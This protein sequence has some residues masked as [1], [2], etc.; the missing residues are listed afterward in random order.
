MQRITVDLVLLVVALAISAVSSAQDYPS[1]P[2]RIIVPYASG[3]GMADR[4]ARLVAEKLQ[5]KWGQPVIV[6]NRAGAAANIGSEYVAKSS[7][8]GY[9][10]L[11]L[12]TGPLAV[13]KS[14]FSKLAYDPDAFVPVSLMVTSPNV[15]IV[16]PKVPANSLQQLIA[17]MTTNPD[18]LNYGS[19]GSGGAP[20]LTAEMFKAMAKVKMVHVPYKGVP[21]AL[22]DLLG[23][24]LDMMFVGLGSVLQQ[25][26]AGKLR[27][28]GVGSEKRS[29]LMPDTPSISE[30]LPGFISGGS[31]GMVAPPGTQP[32]IANKLSTAIAEF[33]KQPDVVKQLL[34]LNLDVIGSTPA[35]MALFLK[36]DS[37]RWGPLIRALG[38]TAE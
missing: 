21:P 35:D 8:D 9:T 6:E 33:L 36:Q 11:Y 20:H 14:L 30:V 1:K 3:G 31:F 19:N 13:N 10:L 7:P 37:E 18:R 2:I 29:Q 5:A 23:G 15:L 22:T 12:E 24:Q 34:D 38:V 17:F 26:R 27:V 16:N 4:M 32:A 25:I 28:L